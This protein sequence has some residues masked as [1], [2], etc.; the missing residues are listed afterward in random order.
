MPSTSGG[1]HSPQSSSSGDHGSPGGLKLNLIQSSLLD[2]EDDE[3]MLAAAEDMELLEYQ[4][5]R[6]TP[7]IDIQEFEEDEDT[8]EQ[9]EAAKKQKNQMFTQVSIIATYCK[10][11]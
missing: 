4:R 1:S 9:R 10:G 11:Y 5:S 2:G 7:K 3:E 8:L 6:S